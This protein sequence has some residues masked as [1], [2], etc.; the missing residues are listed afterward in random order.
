MVVKLAD[1]ELVAT[2]ARSEPFS[3]NV[4]VPDMGDGPPDTPACSVT[5]CPAVAGLGETT[6]LVVVGAAVMVSVSGGDVLELFALSP[7]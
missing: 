7:L 1:P 6:K 3:V 5:N 2:V 4:T